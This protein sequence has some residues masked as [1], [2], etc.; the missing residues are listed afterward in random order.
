MSNC[1]GNGNSEFFPAVACTVAV[2]LLE[3][4]KNYDNLKLFFYIC[5]T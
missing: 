4:E 1:V 5:V 3:G 2:A